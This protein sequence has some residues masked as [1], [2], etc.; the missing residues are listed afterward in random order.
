MVKIERKVTENSQLAIQSLAKEKIKSSGKYNTDE[1]VAALQEIFYNKCYICE[2]KNATEWEV[3]HL[4]PHGG[5]IDL[6]FD[7]ENLFWSCGHCNHIKGKKFTPIL[8]C[9]ELEVDE[10]IAFRKSGYFGKDEKLHF[11]K[12]IDYTDDTEIQMTC[13]LLRRVYYGETPQEQAGA[14]ILRHKIRTELSEFKNYVR[15]YNEATGEDKKDL[16]FTIRN[17]LKSN[18]EFAAFK[19]WIVRDNPNCKDFI[20]CWKN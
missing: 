14:K 12:I 7:W 1:V 3:E 13:S 20:N 17:K 10:I 19:R 16:F 15:D 9:T 6:K 2:N 4:I 18:S 8:N 5:N 11:D